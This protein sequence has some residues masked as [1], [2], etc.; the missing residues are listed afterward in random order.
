VTNDAALR[1]VRGAAL[2]GMPGGIVAVTAT[3]ILA[4]MALRLPYVFLSQIAEGL[5]TTIARL[6]ALLGIAEL[7]GLTTA[8]IGRR[9]DRG[10]T[11][12]WIV[13]GCAS[14]CAGAGLMG[15]ARAPIVFTAGAALSAMGIAWYTT[16]G[17]TWLGHEV[18]Y[19][20]RSR[21]VGLFETSWA[22]SLLIGAPLFGLAIDAVAW[23]FPF[24]VLAVVL[25]GCTA[26]LARRTD[27][28]HT[29]KDA[30]DESASSSSVSSSPLSSSTET[31]ALG[32]E[33][34]TR[35]RGHR[36][37]IVATLL[38]SFTITMAASMVFSVYGSWFENDIGLTTRV[39]GVFS[40]GI[41]FA[42]LAASSATA[43]WTDRIGK[44]RAVVAG[45]VVMCAGIAAIVAGP[46]SSPAA[47]AA[48]ITVFLGFEFAFVSLLSAITEVGGS[49]R[50]L[51]LAVDHG[52]STVSRASAAALATGLYDARGMRSPAVLAL[53]LAATAGTAAAVARQRR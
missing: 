12:T 13:L 3:K 15:A 25:L 43:A 50:G 8:F 32:D 11:R 53:V 35:A 1:R 23:W 49:A 6:G 45:S 47:V 16:A 20:Q 4:T 27:G 48:L 22:L 17:H 46:T 21:A 24:S 14:V 52:L 51:V 36:R 18:A 9:L 2:E 28:A 34:G 40:I 38:A 44:T 19:E 30:P 39:I 29:A 5:G 33:R 26:A 10:A 31:H 7:F 42:E 37:A 41:G